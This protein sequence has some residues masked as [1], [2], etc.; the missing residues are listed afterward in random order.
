MS[1]E[2]NDDG[3][4]VDL[5]FSAVN[6]VI[7]ASIYDSINTT[8]DTGKISDSTS[9]S[10]GDNAS[11]ISND[12]DLFKAFRN[13]GGTVRTP[14]SV[15][16]D[17]E[18]HDS[19]I[20]DTMVDAIDSVGTVSNGAD[21]QLDDAPIFQVP[22][23]L[24]DAQDAADAISPGVTSDAVTDGNIELTEI[25]HSHDAGSIENPF[26]ENQLV[27]V[28]DWYQL[29]MALRKSGESPLVQVDDANDKNRGVLIAF[30]GHMG[31][32]K[33]AV[34]SIIVDKATG[35][36]I[37]DSFARALRGEVDWVIDMIKSS[38]TRYDAVIN[39]VLGAGGVKYDARIIQDVVNALYDDVRQGRVN[40][41]GD[42]TDSV[43][44]ALQE[45]G[46]NLRRSVDPDYWVNKIKTEI[47]GRLVSG[48]NVYLTDARFPN[49]L[50]L[51]HDLGGLD[52]RLN[53]SLDAQA[54]RIM[55]RDGIVVTD[56]MRSHSSETAADDYGAFDLIVDTDGRDVDSVASE[57]IE[58]L[59]II[60]EPDT[61][62]CGHDVNA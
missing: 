17:L 49:E 6:N 2:N 36:W 52:V 25:T 19:I 60:V 46:T 31:A 57:V 58:A 21:N 34:S 54:E 22:Q 62:V 23:Q 44:Y 43:R 41:S 56:E 35:I 10:I 12:H 39:T 5:E 27:Q 18:K 14:P 45:W 9:D 61:V 30:S 20:E 47:I 51:V 42:R 32:G 50:D 26:E 4:I 29:A 40:D 53:V 3:D 37:H 33:D 55:L 1:D 28:D 48:V 7:S 16:R 13:P 15:H 59:G 38:L 24:V 8:K 11:V